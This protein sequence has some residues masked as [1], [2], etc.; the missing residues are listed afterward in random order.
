VSA[1]GVASALVKRPS[2]ARARAAELAAAGRPTRDCALMGGG[3]ESSADEPLDRKRG[4]DEQAPHEKDRAVVDTKRRPFGGCVGDRRRACFFGDRVVPS[5]ERAQRSPCGMRPLDGAMDRF[6]ALPGP[7]V[8]GRIRPLRGRMDRRLVL[9]RRRR[10]AGV[11]RKRRSQRAVH[12][13]LARVAALLAPSTQ[14]GRVVRLRPRRRGELAPLPAGR[15]HARRARSGPADP[16]RPR[17][18]R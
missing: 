10:R 15:G 17:P 1:V 5:L 18:D 9:R 7:R 2:R 14:S 13:V 16:V 4:R 8:R 6:P 3:D 12:L 11:G